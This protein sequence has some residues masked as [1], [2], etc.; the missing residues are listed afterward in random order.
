MQN[1]MRK[2]EAKKPQKHGLGFWR[3]FDMEIERGRGEEDKIRIMRI[4]HAMRPFTK[5]VAQAK[6]KRL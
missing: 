6:G 2:E 4:V 5:N 1:Y 3:D